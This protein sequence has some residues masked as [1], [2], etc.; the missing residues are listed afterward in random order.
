MRNKRDF[1]IQLFTHLMLGGAI[2]A[3]ANVSHAETPVDLGTVQSNAGVDAASGSTQAKKASAPYQA[4]T[5]GSL[6]A[7]QPT[8]IISKHYI[9]ENASA[10]ANYTDIAQIAPSVWSVDPNGPGMMESQS[11]GPFL[12]GFA[13][14]QYNVT[15]DGIPW[16][17]SNDFTQHSTSYFMPQDTGNISVERG[18]GDASNIGNATFGGTIAVTSKD[19]KDSPTFTPY[20]MV[21]SFN[22]KLEG[23]E[24]N[25]GAMHNYGDMSSFIDYKSFS[26]DGYLTNSKLKRQ[27]LFAK[28]VKPLSDSTLL[29]FVTMQ[30]KVHQN[31]PLGTT[32][33]NMQ[34]YGRNYGLNN[35]PTSQNYSGYNYDDITSDFEYLGL[36]SIDNGWKIDNKLYTYAYYHNGFNGSDPGGAQANGT[37]YGATNV[38]GQKMT[39]NYRSVGDLLRLSREIGPGVMNLGG[40]VDHQSNNRWQ[41]EIDFTNGGALNGA[42]LSAATDRAMDDSLTSLQP[43]VDYAWKAS[44]RLTVTPG[45]KYAVFRRTIDA[46]VNQGTG[47]PYKDSHTWTKALPSVTARY[48]LEKNWSA[49]TQVAEGFQAP[50]LNAFYKANPDLGTLKPEQTKNYQIG[51]TWASPR[52]ALSADIYRI[53]FDNKIAASPSGTGT[54]FTNAGGVTYQGVEGEGTYYLGQGL[55]LYGNFS[56]NSAKDNTNH[57]WMANTP[58]NTAG[59]GLIYNKDQFYASLLA[60]HVGSR[61]GDSGQTIPLAAYT[62]TNLATSYT[63]KDVGTWAKAAKVGFQINNLFNRTDIYALGTYDANN[64]PMYFTLPAR[65]FQLTFS[66]DM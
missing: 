1:D 39:M 62:V 54:I 11:G 24:F 58:K 7:T 12:R 56:F 10:G 28:F 63:F 64:N 2:V 40:W 61:F 53:N 16:G 9:Q 31:V 32:L 20:A 48:A 14:G 65:N 41:Y 30:N 27:N 8:S 17:D 19:P 45:L 33:A 50:N 34:K 44:D 26:T 51:T 66:V 47:L 35:D 23:V 15:F 4:P 22:T 13:N 46:S 29:T 60:K 59:V 6:T 55:S 5:K 21:G 49:Y 36:N 18:P 43:Y 57:Q 25:T 52:L 37:V 42:P 38:P 3:S